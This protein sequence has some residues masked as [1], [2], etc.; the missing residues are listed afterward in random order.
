MSKTTK[1]WS[2]ATAL[3]ISYTMVSSSSFARDAPTEAISPVAVSEPPAPTAS[4]ATALVADASLLGGPGE[5]CRARSDCQAGLRCFEGACRDE[6]QGMT[7]GATVDCGGV[8]RCMDNVCVNPNAVEAARWAGDGG[9]TWSDF[10]LE[11]VHG[12]VGVDIAGGP[13]MPLH[14]ETGDTLD[15]AGSVLFAI[16]GGMTFGAGEVGVEFSPMTFLPYADDSVYPDPSLQVLTYVG[17]RLP[18]AGNFHYAMRFGLGV[19]AVNTPSD[20]VVFQQR[21]DLLGF[22]FN[23][24]HL[25]LDF[26]LPSFRHLTDFENG[27][28]FLWQTGVATTYVF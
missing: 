15:V 6:R 27:S 3:V 7:C 23:I 19:V 22:G 24:G 28:M 18:I 11:G 4:P 25:V 16:R 9:G 2:A 21:F 8:L 12:F 5:S 1:C 20:E 14:Y 26:H 10:K 13:S 17:A